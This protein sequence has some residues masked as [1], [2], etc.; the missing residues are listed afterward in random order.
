KIFLKD[1]EQS[2]AAAAL[3]FSSDGT[4][5]DVSALVTVEPQD[6]LADLR[7]GLQNL[8]DWSSQLDD[9][10]LLSRDLPLFGGSLGKALN[11]LTVPE[12]EPISSDR[13]TDVALGAFLGNDSQ[14]L[15]RI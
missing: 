9:D 6:L 14:I 10:G 11:G 4:T 8:S 12:G 7:D 13:E 3:A 2:A 1:V 5:S 15:R